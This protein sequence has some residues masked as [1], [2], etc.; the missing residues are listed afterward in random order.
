MNY[1]P[2]HALLYSAAGIAAAAVI[3]T[4]AFSVE[5]SS[6]GS[7][8]K[9]EPIQ[10]PAAEENKTDTFYRAGDWYKYALSP[11][12]RVSLQNEP[13]SNGDFTFE[14]DSAASLRGTYGWSWFTNSKYKLYDED[15]P[16]SRIIG[17]GFVP[18]NDIKIMLQ[19]QRKSRQS[20][21]PG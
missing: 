7:A 4:A 15:H 10:D 20:L 3:V 17:T 9:M 12:Y 16:V 21:P 6:K 8:E 5:N 14:S 1:T 13:V 18:A 19:G 2:I 11:E